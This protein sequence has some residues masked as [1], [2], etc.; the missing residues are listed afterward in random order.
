MGN[1]LSL[2]GPL[3]VNTAGIPVG[4]PAVPSAAA[5]ISGSTTTDGATIITIPA[6]G[7]WLGT[8]V[9][10][11]ASKTNNASVTTNV[12]TLGTTVTP[13]TGAVVAQM[14]IK[15]GSTNAAGVAE[16]AVYPNVIIS[17]GSS[18]AT[19]VGH[20]GAADGYAVNAYGVLL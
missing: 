7:T 14:V 19:L 18:S 9:V 17:A 2:G 16:S 4:A 20:I 15:T 8:I 1:M 3:P 13:A 11:S 6:N 5:I 10:V 12:T